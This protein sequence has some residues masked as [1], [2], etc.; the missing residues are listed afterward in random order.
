MMIADNQLQSTDGAHDD[1][2]PLDNNQIF[3]LTFSGSNVDEGSTIDQQHQAMLQV[4]DNDDDMHHH[5][6]N[7]GDGDLSSSLLGSN[8]KLITLEN[9]RMFMTTADTSAKGRYS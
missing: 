5:Q 2:P 4:D 7:C 3:Y 9:G 8:I 6:A 1:E